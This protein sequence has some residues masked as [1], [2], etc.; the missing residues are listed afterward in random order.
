M[1]KVKQVDGKQFEAEV[2]Q[3]DI[4][5]LIDFYASWCPPCRALGP[6]L[7]RLAGEFE[8]KIKFVKVDSD[9]E[10]ELSTRFKVTGLPTVVFM[11]NGV[12]VGQ[13]AG[14]PQEDA[15]RTELAKWVDSGKVA[16]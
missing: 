8:G 9:E 5:V 11:D 3:S 16:P 2:L 14:L 1:S 6:I 7:D 13:F 10:P 12:N 4:P 15:L